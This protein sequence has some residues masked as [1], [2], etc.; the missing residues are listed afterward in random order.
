MNESSKSIAYGGS[1]ELIV[2]DEKLDLYSYLMDFYRGRWIVSVFGLIGILLAGIYLFFAEP[3]WISSSKILPSEEKS[4]TSNLSGLAA[5]AGVSMPEQPS[6]EILYSDILLSRDFLDTLLT[7]RW[8]ST[9]SPGRPS[10][11]AEL[12]EIGIDSTKPNGP[13]V[14]MDKLLASLQKKISFI[15]HPKTGLMVL[16]VAT[17]NPVLSFEIN[18]FLLEHL[19][20][21]N[22][23]VKK[24]KASENRKFI[25]QNTE[26]MLSNL[27]KAEEALRRFREVNHTVG[28]PGLMLELERYL[29]EVEINRSLYLEI[30]KQYELARVE[31][32]KSTN[33]LNVLETPVVPVNKS[34]PRR[35]IILAYGLFL[36][37]LVGMALIGLN[38]AWVRF[39]LLRPSPA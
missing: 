5:L 9:A 24:T 28:T 38:S 31:E 14:Q 10:T 25:A 34:A 1:V 15:K 4:Q 33:L 18:K 35:K 37:L 17:N 27:K 20:S 30:R 23:N 22:R 3:V 32:F 19:D 13:A 7:M 6:N 21:Y 8:N 12:W 36:G 11:L 16:D 2:K 39:K 29:Q 26:E